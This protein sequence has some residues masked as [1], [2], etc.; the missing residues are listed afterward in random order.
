MAS[1]NASTD[2]TNMPVALESLDACAAPNSQ[3]NPENPMATEEDDS[4]KGSA[5]DEENEERSP[6]DALI[7]QENNSNNSCNNKMT[8]NSIDPATK[9]NIE[10]IKSL[11][12]LISNE[13]MS[14]ESSHHQQ[15]V[16]F[17]RNQPFLKIK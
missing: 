3:R 15:S 1:L 17:R 5:E 11:K 14:N 10:Q 2:A 6:I 4:E 13:E 9:S 16:S 7:D 8:V 12:D